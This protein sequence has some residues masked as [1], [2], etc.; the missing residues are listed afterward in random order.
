M[1]ILR[2]SIQTPDGTIITS[3]HQHDYVQ[4]TDKNGLVYAV[5][6]GMSY[7]RRVGLLDFKEM[8]LTSSDPFDRIREEFEWGSRG[9]DGTACLCYTPLKDLTEKHIHAIMTTQFKW[10]SPAILEI[11]RKELE[12]RK[13][14][15]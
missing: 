3:R 6:G 2:N 10:L 15:D 13:K 9:E 4:H 7:L 11:F 12:Y 14:N 8:S 1:T 5:D